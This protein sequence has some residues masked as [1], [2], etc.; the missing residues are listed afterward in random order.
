MDSLVLEGTL[1][2]SAI[3]Q[4]ESHLSSYHKQSISRAEAANILSVALQ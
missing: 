3:S 1:S 2:P 4:I